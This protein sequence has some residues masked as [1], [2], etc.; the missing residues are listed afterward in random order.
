MSY[1][2]S[3]QTPIGVTNTTPQLQL[4]KYHFEVDEETDL[5][6]QNAFSSD[7]VKIAMTSTAH[8]IKDNSYFE[9]MSDGTWSMQQS[10]TAAYTK[11]EVDALLAAKQDVLTFDS[12]PTDSSTNPVTSG[13][14]YTSVAEVAD[15]G[16]K[17]VLHITERYREHNGVTFT[18]NSDES[19]LI[20]GGTT[21]SISY[22]RLTGSQSSTAYSDQIPIKKG[23]YTVRCPGATE[24]DTF[25]FV[26]GYRNNSGDSRHTLQCNSGNLFTAEFEITTDTGRFDATLLSY[27]TASSYSATVYPMV[28][29]SDIPGTDFQPYAPTNRELYEMIL[30]L[31]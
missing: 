28:K 1:W 18:V 5:P 27:R 22:I 30:E 14:V 15:A 24:Q 19:V 9:M 11:S 8:V 3:S 10:G 20:S 12:T 2:V 6:A 21:G 17:N 29:R 31:L 16:A 26:I 25:I 7:G 23:K 13:G 4:I